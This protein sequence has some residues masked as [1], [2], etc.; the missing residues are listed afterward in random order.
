MLKHT[1]HMWMCGAMVAAAL[2]VL[3]VTGNVGVF[4]PAIACVLMMGLMMSMM[5]SQGGADKDR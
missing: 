4:V 1:A 2:V 3:V 5:G